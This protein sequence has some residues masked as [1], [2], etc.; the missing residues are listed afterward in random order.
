MPG[1]RLRRGQQGARAA[2][3]DVIMSLHGS[4]RRQCPRRRSSS[5]ETMITSRSSRDSSLSGTSAHDASAR[6]P[7]P[8]LRPLLT[9]YSLGSQ[10]SPH[11]ISIKDTMR[12]FR[13]LVGK[14]CNGPCSVFHLSLN[15]GDKSWREGDCRPSLN[16]VQRGWTSVT[17]ETSSFYHKFACPRHSLICH[18]NKAQHVQTRISQDEMADRRTLQIE[19]IPALDADAIPM[20]QPAAFSLLR[21]AKNDSCS[22]GKRQARWPK[23]QK[24]RMSAR[25]ARILHR[26]ASTR[27]RRGMIV[28]KGCHR[29]HK[30]AHPLCSQ[31]LSLSVP[32]EICI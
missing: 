6:V 18:G 16:Q 15:K 13:T 30:P 12:M 5:S 11:K 19:N 14:R 20:K 31:K 4:S 10:R 7:W 8:P 25:A 24:S 28:W 27:Q 17:R 9:S 2:F 22:K 26:R 23:R 1:R 21:S 29:A 3:A 32:M